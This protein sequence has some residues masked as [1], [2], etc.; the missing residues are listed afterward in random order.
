M[1]VL[2]GGMPANARVLDRGVAVAAVDA[3]AADVALVAELDRLL[4]RDVRLGDPG[5]PIHLR[6]EPQQ[7]QPTKNT[8]P[9]MLTRAIVFVLR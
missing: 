1:Q 6:D 2:V 9:K 3:V 7:R 8:A 4:A 5:R